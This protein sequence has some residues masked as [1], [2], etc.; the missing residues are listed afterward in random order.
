MMLAANAHD[1]L[2][3]VSEQPAL[4][5]EVALLGLVAGMAGGLFGIG[6][7]LIIIPALALL[8]DGDLKVF[9][10]AALPVG[11]AVAASSVGKHLRTDAIQWRWVWWAAPLSFVGAYAGAKAAT[12]ADERLLEIV[13][14]CFLAASALRESWVLLRGTEPMAEQADAAIAPVP[15]L[16]GSLGVLMGSLSALL[17]IGGGVLAVPW[18]RAFARFPL[19]Q[20][21][22]TSSVLVFITSVFATFTRVFPIL[23]DESVE[24]IREELLLAAVLMPGAIAGGYFGAVLVH[25]LPVK[26]LMPVFILLLLGFAMRMFIGR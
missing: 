24:G 26:R 4:T 18:L 19:R 3:S 23:R 2:T 10:V 6:G 15:V 1:L 22:A 13:F 9:Q 8:M 12:I 21:V 14:G 17:G 7:G 16:G 20:T 5:A 25:R 11:V